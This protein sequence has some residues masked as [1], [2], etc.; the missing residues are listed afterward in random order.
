MD[1]SLDV[2][3]G[4][5]CLFAFVAGKGSGHLAGILAVDR[6]GSDFDGCSVVIIVTAGGEA[7]HT[8]GNRQHGAEPCC[9]EI[10]FFH[11]LCFELWL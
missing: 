6:A 1:S 9:V 7:R 8:G 5:F 3:D 10:M 2:G 11:S 4:R